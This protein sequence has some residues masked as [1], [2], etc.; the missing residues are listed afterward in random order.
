MTLGDDLVLDVLS[1]GLGP[2]GVRQT[3]RQ[4][5]VRDFQAASVQLAHHAVVREVV[6]Y[7]QRRRRRTAVGVPPASIR[8]E[9]AEVKVPVVPVDGIIEGDQNHLGHLLRFEASGDVVTRTATARGLAVAA[10]AS[11]VQS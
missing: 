9:E 11:V 10:G 5:V 1:R 7:E 4:T 6:G 2:P 3:V 8:R